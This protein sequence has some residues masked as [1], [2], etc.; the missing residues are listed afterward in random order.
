MSLDERIGAGGRKLAAHM[1]RPPGRPSGTPPAVVLCHGYPSAAGA[2]L[3]TPELADRI[4]TEMGWVVLAFAFRGCGE[5]EGQFSLGGWL[6]DVGVAVSHVR[7]ETRP[8]GVWIA[9][10]GTGGALAVCA[11]A[12]APW[13]NGVAAIGAPGDFDDWASHP[14]RLVE[15]AREVGVI[16]DRAFP[17]SF[18]AWAR[19]LKAVRAVACASRLAPRP[20]LVLHGSEDEAVPPFDARV[21]AD[22]HGSAELRF[23]NGAGHE[24]RYDP[25]AVAVLLGWLDRQRHN[26]RR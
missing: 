18:D 8:L 1:A 7:A 21:L 6:E 22:A 12:R 19:E 24:L 3:T 20:L 10:F 14:R 4:A 16:T 23:I 13:V 17:P 25:R 9:G 26:L 11:G 2:G 15:H 5:S